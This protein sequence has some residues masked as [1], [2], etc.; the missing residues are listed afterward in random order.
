MKVD[1]KHNIGD[2]VIITDIDR[3]G[4]IESLC[5]DICGKQYRVVYWHDGQRRSEW[6]H[7]WEIS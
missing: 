4:R 3:P 5:Q 1:F 6:M 7:E 2:E